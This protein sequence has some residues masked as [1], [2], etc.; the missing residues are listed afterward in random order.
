[1]HLCQHSVINQSINHICLE[2]A[3][4]QSEVTLLSTGVQFRSA[5]VITIVDIAGSPLPVALKLKSLGVIIDSYLRFDVHVREVVKACNHHIRALRHVR[6]V[7]SDETA[8]M[9]ACSIVTSRLDYCSLQRHPIWCSAVITRQTTAS[10]KQSGKGR[11][12]VKPDHCFHPSSQHTGAVILLK[13]HWQK[14][15]PI[16]SVHLTPVSTPVCPR[17]AGHDSSV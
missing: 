6:H 11:V 16:L 17:S 9:I 14:F 1:M 7:L 4:Y 12:S 5:A 3:G 10:A 13:L 2:N 15:I 8:H